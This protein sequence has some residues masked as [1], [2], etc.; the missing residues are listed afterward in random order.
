MKNIKSQSVDNFNK[1]MK[2]CIGKKLLTVAAHYT[3][4]IHFHG[5]ASPGTFTFSILPPAVNSQTSRYIAH[6]TSTNHHLHN[7]GVNKLISTSTQNIS[8]LQVQWACEASEHA[9]Q[10]TMNPRTFWVL[11]GAVPCRSSA[12]LVKAISRQLSFQSG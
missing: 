5:V 8:A 10:N 6:N 9:C 7:I 11:L 1:L 12:Y 4:S 3:F 2:L